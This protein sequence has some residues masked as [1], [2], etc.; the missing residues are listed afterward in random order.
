MYPVYS[1]SEGK[2]EHGFFPLASH[3]IGHSQIVIDGYVGVLWDHFQAQLDQALQS[4]GV[5]ADWVS[6]SQALRPDEE[7]ETLIEPF[8]GDDDPIFGKR[9][10][11]TLADFFDAQ[12]ADT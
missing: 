10:T 12:E 8:L 6:V 2:I 1:L 4:H 7:I 5:H 3:L 11:G 9:F